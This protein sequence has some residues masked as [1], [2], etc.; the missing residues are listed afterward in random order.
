M[1]LLVEASGPHWVSSPVNLSSLLFE[2][3]SLLESGA[4]RYAR[5][6]RQPSP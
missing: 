1:P 5:L 3:K 6:V 2:A 4:G